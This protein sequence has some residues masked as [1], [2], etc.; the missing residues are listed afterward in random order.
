M[1]RVVTIA[2]H[3]PRYPILVRKPPP[4]AYA[5]PPSSARFGKTFP[6]SRLYQHARELARTVS[7]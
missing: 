2:L 1:K 4:L 6:S 3:L 5:L 7:D